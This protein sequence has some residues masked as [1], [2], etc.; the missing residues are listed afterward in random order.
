MKIG[1]IET[2]LNAE[3]ERRGALF[4]VLLDPDTSDE[5]SGFKRLVR[6]LQRMA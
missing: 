2:L 4:A 6:L 5:K 1:K 3:I